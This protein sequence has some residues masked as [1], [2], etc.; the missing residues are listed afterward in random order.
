MSAYITPEEYAAITGRPAEEATPALIGK[1]S[2]QIDTLTFERIR[3][4][5]FGALYPLQQ[6]IIR[7][8]CARQAAFLT[9]YGDVL[10]APLSSYSIGNV[11]MSWD[12]GRVVQISGVTMEADVYARLLRTGLCAKEI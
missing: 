7:T 1:V 6:E 3:R 11:S 8:V 10:D 4:I 12:P 5:G 2:E 9:D